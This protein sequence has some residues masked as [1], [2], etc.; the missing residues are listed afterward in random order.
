MLADSQNL[1]PRLGSLDRELQLSATFTREL[2]D[3]IAQE[4]PAWRD[5]PRRPDET[6][7]ARLS[8]HLCSYLNSAARHSKGWDILQFRQEVP[9]ETDRLRTLDL[10]AAPC[11]VTLWVDGRQT[12]IFDTILPIECK[13]LPTPVATDRDQREYVFSKHSS[14][15]GIQRFKEGHH[16]ATHSLAAMIG[17]IQEGTTAAWHTRTTDWI[18]GLIAAQERGW[19]AGD[20]IHLDR[21][22]SVN[23]IAVLSSLHTR[24]DGRTDIELCHLWIQMD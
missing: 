8:D 14:T 11:G 10:V 12:T 20:Q 1:T 22:D 19:S 21:N 13:R 15:G 16:G 3:F 18:N 5:H 2:L 6:S 17:Y 4:L 23:K 24:A 7:E 9:D